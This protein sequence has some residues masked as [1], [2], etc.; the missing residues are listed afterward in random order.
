MSEMSRPIVFLHIPKTAGQT[1]F[2][3]IASKVGLEHTSPIRDI[4]QAPK[5]QSHLPAGYRFYAGHIDWVDL[6]DLPAPYT[7]TVVRNP[8]ERLASLYF[9]LLAQA[10]TRTKEELALP[11]FTG[12][13]IMLQRSVDDYF[14]G[15]DPPWRR[16]IKN[17][18]DNYITTYLATR[19][20]RGS[21]ALD[22]VEA[23]AR[24][25]AALAGVRALDAIYEVSD[26]RALEDDMIPLLGTRITLAGNHTN[27]GNL[28]SGQSRWE[29]L[30]ARFETDAAARRLDEFVSSDAD[31]LTRIPIRTSIETSP[32]GSLAVHRD[33]HAAAPNHAGIRGLWNRT[34]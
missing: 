18:Y 29:A 7:F 28:D 31:L 16:F 32:R 11:R 23:S 34:S 24:L 6:P 22:G 17:N 2:H 15:G 20:V 26:L 3:Q 30:R 8:R 21:K 10:R 19:Q 25:E 33:T 12:Q 13:R 5:G 4:A 27:V 1:I 14:F 9:Y